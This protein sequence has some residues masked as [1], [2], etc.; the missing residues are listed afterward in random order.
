M[1]WCE[2]LQGCVFSGPT[3]GLTEEHD[4]EGK[5]AVYTLAHAALLFACSQRKSKKALSYPQVGSAP[6]RLHQFSAAI[7]CEILIG[8]GSA[9]EGWGK[10]LQVGSDG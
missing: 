9:A 6:T 10:G 2:E 7:I 1:P 8:F 4:Y 5:L 3:F